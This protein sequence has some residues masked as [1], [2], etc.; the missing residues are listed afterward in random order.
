MKTKTFSDAIN[1]IDSRYITEAVSYRGETKVVPWG[2]ISVAAAAI[3]IRQNRQK[4]AEIE[5]K[6]GLTEG[7][8]RKEYIS[9]TLSS[10]E[11]GDYIL[12]NNVTD[13]SELRLAGDFREVSKS[14]WQEDFNISLPEAE[15]LAFHLVYKIEKG[16]DGAVYTDDLLC[17][18]VGQS[19]KDKSFWYMF[20][21]KQSLNTESA[22]FICEPLANWQESMI[23]GKKILLSQSDQ[24]RRYA[25]FRTGD[26]SVYITMR[27]MDEAEAISL[28]KK[29]LN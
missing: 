11:S 23:D 22:Y 28:L 6:V 17:G 13:S 26:C 1:V 16:E 14:R 12:W 10:F 3:F 2:K 19:N 20:V 27:D 18:H 5:S 15:K 9:G 25:A 21:D 4:I 7:G 29:L 8:M 24:Y